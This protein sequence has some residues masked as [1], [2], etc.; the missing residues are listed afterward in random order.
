MSYSTETLTKESTMGGERTVNNTFTA[1]HTYNTSITFRATNKKTTCNASHRI[2]RVSH[3][4]TA[5]ACVAQTSGM[6]Y[7]KQ[8][9]RTQLPGVFGHMQGEP[10]QP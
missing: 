9:Q 7:F 1:R 4:I 6:Y 2:L 3:N 10:T 8:G 5:T